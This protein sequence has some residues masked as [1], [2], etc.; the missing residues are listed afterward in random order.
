[1]TAPR[2][3]HPARMSQGIKIVAPATHAPE[4]G[5]R[6]WDWASR[7]LFWLLRDAPE[8]LDWLDA[9][10]AGLRESV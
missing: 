9:N 3:L 4:L 6:L 1:M 10:L 8:A 2:I 5:E 7:N